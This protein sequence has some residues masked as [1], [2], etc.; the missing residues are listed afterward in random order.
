MGS[1]D[2]GQLNTFKYDYEHGYNETSAFYSC[3][4]ESFPYSN[5]TSSYSMCI[6]ACASP[7]TGCMANNCSASC[8]ASS[9]CSNSTTNAIKEVFK[10]VAFTL[11]ILGAF[12]LIWKIWLILCEK[13]KVKLF[14]V[15]D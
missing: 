5:I 6:Q 7:C 3:F 1:S 12:L 15:S 14:Y 4:N 10:V 11:M 2:C 13:K 9:C 8:A